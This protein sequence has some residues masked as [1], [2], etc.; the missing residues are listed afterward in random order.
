MTLSAQAKQ[1]VSDF[2]AENPNMG[3]IK[4]RAKALKTNHELAKELW[5][6]GEFQP[7]LLAVLI[8]DKKLLTPE[9]IDQLAAEMMDHDEGERAHIA[10]WFLAN[11][12]TKTKPLT[13]L[14]ETWQN[15]KSPVLQR[16]FWYYQARLR[17]MGKA[18]PTNSDALMEAIEKN[19]ASADPFVQWTMNFCAGQIGIHEP[20]YR[21]RIVKL[22][23]ELGLYKE[24]RVS[25][26]CTPSYLPEFIRIE[27]AKREKADN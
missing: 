24:E 15:N 2:A 16:L 22:G 23:E 17:W 12:L 11:Q 19:L 5:S 1:I 6:T 13:A 9:F 27:V 8:F 20:E 3:D 26:N 25:K 14:L 7:R 4:K 10:D 18:Q 21:D